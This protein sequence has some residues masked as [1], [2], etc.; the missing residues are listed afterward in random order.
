MPITDVQREKIIEAHAEANN[1][2]GLILEAVNTPW[3]VLALIDKVDTAEAHISAVNMINH[4]K[5]MAIAYADDL[6]AYL[7]ALP[8]IS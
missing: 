1:K 2:V 3:Q 4:S 5:A 7:V 8:D 6:K